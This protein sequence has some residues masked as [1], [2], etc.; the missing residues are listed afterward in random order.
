MNIF[1][2]I[3]FGKV[4]GE[5]EFSIIFNENFF[6]LVCKIAGMENELRCRTPR[7]PPSS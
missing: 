2:N 6:F 1:S 5:H 4:L 3:F 7:D